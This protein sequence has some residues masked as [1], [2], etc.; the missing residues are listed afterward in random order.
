MVEIRQRSRHI[1]QNDN[2]GFRLADDASDIGPE[3]A[4]VGVSFPLPG[5]R[6]GL[7]REARSHAI[8]DT[9]PRASVE[10]A[11]VAPDR[12]PVKESVRH[13]GEE[14]VLAERVEL[15]ATDRSGFWDRL[16]DPEVEPA[17]S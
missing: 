10:G 7:A 15:G 1:F 12:S 14:D 11:E 17:D 16:L 3:V 4:G 13:P 9:A 2:C 5:G 6:E 8:H